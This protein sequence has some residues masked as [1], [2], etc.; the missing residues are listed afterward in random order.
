[1]RSM[2]R[3]IYHSPGVSRARV[4]HF[5]PGLAILLGTGGASI[6]A[7]SDGHEVWFSLPF[8]VGA[9]LTLD[10]LGLLLELDN[11]YWNGERFA[12]AQI[13]ATAGGFSAA[14]AFPPGGKAMPL[15]GLPHDAAVS[16]DR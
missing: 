12:F 5:T 9:G 14:R 10:E 8:G 7:R 16:G 2:G 4:H 6:F 15:D 3:R 11:P 1:M 13:A